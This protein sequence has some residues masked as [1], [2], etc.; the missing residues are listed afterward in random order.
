MKRILLTLLLSFILSTSLFGQ[1]LRHFP[2]AV[3]PNGETVEL[4]FTAPGLA[5]STVLEASFFY[6]YANDLSFFQAPARVHDGRI[7][8][9]FTPGNPNSTS[10]HYFLRVELDNGTVLTYPSVDPEDEPVEVSLVAHGNGLTNASQ[11]VS[12]INYSIMTPDPGSTLNPD[13]FMVAITFFY[14]DDAEAENASFRLLIN[15]EDVSESADISPYLMTFIPE[16]ALPGGNTSIEVIVEQA[17]VSQTLVSFQTTLSERRRQMEVF[18]DIGGPAVTPRS[19]F[20]PRGQIEVAA[21]SQSYGG[22]GNESGRTSFRFS[23]S[24]GNIR[25]SVNGLF[26]TE[27]NSRLQAQNRFGAELYVGNW[28]ELQAGHIYPTLNPFL[29]SG[30]RVYGVN[31][32]LK[33]ANEN[34]QLQFIYG[35]LTRAVKPIYGDLQ[36][37]ITPIT[38]GAGNP[39]LNSNGDVIADTTFAISPTGTGFGTY[40]RNITGVRFG[41]GSGRTFAWNMNA[42]RIEDDLNS[43]NVISNFN[44]LNQA[45]LN[46]LTQDERAQ[47]AANPG[48]LQARQGAAD[49]Q[50]NVAL[51]TDFSFRFD[52]GRVQWRTDLAGSLLNNDISDGILTAERAED[53][54]WDLGSDISDVFDRLS[55]LIVINENMNSLPLRIND[56][57][58]EAF[59]PGGIFAGNSQLNLNYFNHNLTVQ[60]RWIGPDFVSLA[61]TTQRRDI[62]GYT[63]TDRFRM[64][65]NSIF[66]TLGHEN[67]KDNVINN[68][69]ATT[70]SITN[71]ANVSWFPQDRMLP[72]ISL[73]VRHR[74]RD[75]NVERQ[76]PLLPENLR[77]VAV[78][79]VRQSP[80]GDFF[81]LPNP[82]DNATLQFTGSVTQMF[83]LMNHDHDLNVNFSTVNTKD[84]VFAFGDFKS[85]S[86]GFQLMTRFST[87]PLRTTLGY[88]ILTTDALSGLNKVD[89]NGFNLGADYVLMQNKLSLNL[90]VAFTMNKSTSI[91]LLAEQFVPAGGLPNSAE[92]RALMLFYTQDNDPQ[93]VSRSESTAFVISGGGRYDFTRNHSVF[94]LF[95]YTT[96]NDQ[97]TNFNLPNDHLI[98]VRYVTRF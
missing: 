73:G 26:T 71:R 64:F 18:S 88:N 4:E 83:E 49:P 46:Q 47:L 48:L 35:E 90:D 70:T 75:N 20:I 51:A 41:I 52:E 23:G 98:Q 97:L 27:E 56:G 95:N 16:T 77:N 42:L 15:G 43:I 40:K 44:S 29:I 5:A 39:I 33:L 7:S 69:D 93:N 17:G 28:F 9:F 11:V 62:A 72:R 59:V 19:G 79:N 80:Q 2:P 81:T 36:R 32:G 8:M 45:Q 60:Y 85:N 87:L 92:E 55:W 76:N 53:L 1:T 14:E 96:L 25:Y 22:F 12:N 89:V 37:V 3:I 61:N 24:E 57:K 10:L 68:R 21:R 74:T 65:S 58:A 13:D 54:G 31:T 6:R 82:R 30:N 86:F 94:L 78:R 63:I 50:G 91:P 84:N 38:D 34:L 66:V 67:L